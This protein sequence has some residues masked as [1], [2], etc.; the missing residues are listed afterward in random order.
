MDANID[1]LKWTRDDLP[2]SDST[3]R[4][5]PLIDQLFSQ[6]LPHGVSQLV[7]VPTR[8]WPGTPDSGLDHIYSNKPS[9]LSEVY[10][11]FSGGSDHKLLK[12]TRYSKSMKKNVRYVERK[13]SKKLRRRISA[14]LRTSF[15]GGT[16][17]PVKI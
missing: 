2:S 16:S 10:T 5:R 6:I 3:N 4:L 15:P 11:E 17:T 1:F 8:F 14:K 9:K 13:F 12:I 7:T